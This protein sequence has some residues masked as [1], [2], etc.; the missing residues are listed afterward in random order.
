M[1]YWRPQETMNS[2]F[3][4][5]L[6]QGIL[7]TISVEALAQSTGIQIDFARISFPMNFITVHCFE[8]F[9]DCLLAYYIHLLRLL[10]RITVPADFDVL[11]AEVFALLD[12]AFFNRGGT[13]AAYTESRNGFHGGMRLILDQVTD[14][15]KKE[16]MEKR[17]NQVLRYSFDP[18][19]WEIKVSLIKD[20]LKALKPNLP[21]EIYHQPPERFGN[22]YEILVKSYVN[23]MDQ[24]KYSFQ[25][26]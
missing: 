12:R 25:A 6:L 15:F 26:L 14:Q 18:I 19:D 2:N 10:N 3:K 4:Q 11:S 20:L 21:P 22:H 23:S 17:V 13:K 8:E 16:E 1:F 24:V 7:S 9:S 5:N